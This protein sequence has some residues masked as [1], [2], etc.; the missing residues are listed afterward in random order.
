V[1]GLARINNADASG[2]RMEE[3]GHVAAI[4]ARVSPFTSL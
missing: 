3:I 1:E 2:R 4:L